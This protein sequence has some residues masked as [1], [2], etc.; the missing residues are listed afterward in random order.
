MTEVCGEQ[1]IHCETG[2]YF[3]KLFPEKF[4][5]TWFK[6]LVLLFYKTD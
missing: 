4:I 1:L 3:M 2:F 5:F 6:V